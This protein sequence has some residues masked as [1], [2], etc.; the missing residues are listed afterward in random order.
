MLSSALLSSRLLSCTD[1]W[2][3]SSSSTTLDHLSARSALYRQSRS[4]KLEADSALAEGL[5][6]ACITCSHETPSNTDLSLL[7]HPHPGPAVPAAGRGWEAAGD[8]GSW[9]CL[10]LTQTPGHGGW[11]MSPRSVTALKG[12]A[13]SANNHPTLHK[14]VKGE[15]LKK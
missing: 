13:L 6:A 12:S 2:S 10:G 9:R 11:G 8:S 15:N 1:T 14:E 5:A 3:I 7:C 4:S